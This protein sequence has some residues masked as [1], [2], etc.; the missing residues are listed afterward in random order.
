MSKLKCL[1]SLSA[2][3]MFLAALGATQESLADDEHHGPRPEAI[4]ACKEKKEGD[5]CTFEGRH[6][7]VA[8]ACRKV[9][10]GDL[11]CVRPHHDHDGAAP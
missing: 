6:G 7:A 5:S 8:G 3:A 10:T 9:H 4:A 1:L 2:A 11:A